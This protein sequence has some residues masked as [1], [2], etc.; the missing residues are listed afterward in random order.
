M[1]ISGLTAALGAAM[2]LMAAG[3]ASAQ[4]LYGARGGNTAGNLYTINPTTA[5][6]T[7]V[8]PIG[9][10]VTGMAY[11]ATAGVMYGSTSTLSPGCAR[12]LITINLTTGAGTVVGPMAL[13]N[14]AADIAWSGTVLYGWSEATDELVTINTSTGLAT[15][16]GPSGTG[17]AGDGMDF[18]GGVLYAAL[19]GDAGVLSVINTTTGFAGPGPTMTGTGRTVSSAT[20]Q[21]S[22][23]LLFASETGGTLFTINPT[24]G[25]VTNIGPTAIPN[26]DAV[27]FAGPPPVTVPT[28]S[29]WAM[30]GFGAL[31]AMAGALW[32]QRRR[33]GL[34]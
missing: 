26:F 16:V 2:A 19:N 31:L 21:V 32:V 12:C 29:E 17:S 18:V 14:A 25:V 5:V 7:V 33:F 28:L 9:F 11:N 27:E 34:A 10:A 30:I 23:G 22:S 20:T 13:G 15:V 1:K 4:T 6:S 8:G 24:N 3:T